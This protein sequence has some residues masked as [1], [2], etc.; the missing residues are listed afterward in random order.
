MIQKKLYFCNANIRPEYCKQDSNVCCMY[1]EFKKDCIILYK[2][3]NSKIKPCVITTQDKLD[4]CEFS[5]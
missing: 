1:C 3:R 5:C 2:E 4:I